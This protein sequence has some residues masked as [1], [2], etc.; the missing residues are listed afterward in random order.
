M[1]NQ[2]DPK[3]YVLASGEAHTIKEFI[4]KA[5]KTAN[6]YG[7]WKEVDGSP[8]E[9]AFL[10][11]TSR[12]YTPLVTVSEDFYRPAEVDVLLGDSTPIREELGWKPKISFDMLVEKMVK[13]DIEDY[14]EEKR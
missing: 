13:F 5:F 14:K 11:G 3:D 12:G 4:E 7:S 10:L 1:L 6:I 9:T 2:D 8:L